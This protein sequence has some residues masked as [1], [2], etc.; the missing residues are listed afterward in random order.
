MHT[1]RAVLHSFGNF[2]SLKG[3]CS[4]GWMQFHSSQCS[5][6]T[7]WWNK[8]VDWIGSNM[9]KIHRHDQVTCGLSRCFGKQPNALQ[10]C[11]E[12][13]WTRM[14]KSFCLRMSK[15]ILE[16]FGRQKLSELNILTVNLMIS[17]NL[18][19]FYNSLHSSFC[20]TQVLPA[21]IKAMPRPGAALFF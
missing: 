16:M 5:G 9:F 21:R 15:T 13:L 4:T 14:S 3:R 11:Q 1:I 12:P 19:C 6:E 7:D 10:A 2:L 17:D 18:K 8:C 20:R